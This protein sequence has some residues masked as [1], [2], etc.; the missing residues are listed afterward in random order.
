MLFYYLK[1]SIRRLLR[2]KVY[3]TV[4]ILGLALALMS[5][6]L[7]FKFAYS[8]WQTDKWHSD[9]DN[10][11]RFLS[12]DKRGNLSTGVQFHFLDVLRKRVPEIENSVR[13]KRLWNMTIVLDSARISW[14]GRAF[15]TERSLFEMFDYSLVLGDIGDFAPG[16]K[17]IVLSEKLAKRFFGDENPVG[18]PF[19]FECPSEDNTGA[20]TVVAVMR[21]APEWSSLKP[22][23]L[24]TIDQEDESFA[25]FYNAYET[26]VKLPELAD[27]KRFVDEAVKASWS[28]RGKEYKAFK[29]DKAI[30]QPF[31]NIYLHSKGVRSIRSTGSLFYTR[32]TAVVAI[33]ILFIALYNFNVIN[34]ALEI[35]TNV[36]TGVRRCLGETKWME[37]AYNAIDTGV[38]LFVA[39]LLM[40]LVMP[41]AY[42]FINGILNLFQVETFQFDPFL[43]RVFFFV[44]VI[45]WFWLFSSTVFRWHRLRNVFKAFS[46]Q[47]R[48]VLQLVVILT[49]LISTAFFVKQLR[50]IRN[51]SGFN[52]D[53]L[54]TI[55]FPNPIGNRV[56]GIWDEV[57]FRNKF[58]E[59]GYA[60]ACALG[61]ILPKSRGRKLQ[62][63]Q[64]VGNP[65]RKVQKI[66]SINGDE[67][68][69]DLY[70][71]K[72]VEGRGLDR[73]RFL[74]PGKIKSQDYIPEV[75]VNETFV[76]LM[77]LKEPIGEII[78][79]VKSKTEKK[80]IVGV[81]KDFHVQSFFHTIKPLM[82]FHEK[83]NWA[84]I[85]AKPGKGKELLTFA[86]SLHQRYNPDET[87]SF[88]GSAE[89][90]NKYYLKE[91]RFEKILL[92]FTALGFFIV[93]LGLFGVSY[94]T[95]ETRTKE[96]GIRKANG[97]TTF[98]I[99]RL[100]NSSTLK[101]VAIAFVIAVPIA[102]YAMGRWLENFA[103]KTEM[104]WWVFVGAGLLSGLVALGTVSWQ[105]W[106]AASREPVEALRYE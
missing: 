91:I 17:K 39:S 16:S 4:N 26:L 96:I 12:E 65:E 46:M 73:K 99:L 29:N 76:R 33:L 30:L 38:Q 52:A 8:E 21:N 7:L 78:Q 43:W 100:L 67:H 69:L 92:L 70:N 47:V 27:R 77:G 55:S 56:N 90:A 9:T 22:D 59:S 53:R 54:Y 98:E 80:R 87:Q 48:T 31:S 19:D 50:F 104:S 103:Y 24:K 79:N 88:L 82:I 93:C 63:F 75:L 1:I 81:V 51:S 14:S 11:Y 89:P 15:A 44:F 102:Y 42:P 62:Q 83:G 61:T 28:Y 45:S 36:S 66:I 10:V 64:A 85:K 74:Y 23:L 84:L 71:I 86:E 3:A 58:M 6:L 49:L 2:D 97:A 32:G 25:Y 5:S 106:R 37:Y 94:F 40:L 60:D 72:L 34:G 57:F 101:Q 18:K 105:S 20:Y 95:A 68:Y 41:W 35:K 13:V